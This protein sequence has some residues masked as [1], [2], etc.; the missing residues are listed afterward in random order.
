MYKNVNAIIN[1]HAQTSAINFAIK[2]ALKKE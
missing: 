2:N 1:K